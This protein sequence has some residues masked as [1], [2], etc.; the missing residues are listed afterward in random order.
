MTPDQ[1]THALKHREVTSIGLASALSAVNPIDAYV[2]I[3]KAVANWSG[4]C[5]CFIIFFEKYCTI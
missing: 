4:A 1:L 5:V 2:L 3:Y